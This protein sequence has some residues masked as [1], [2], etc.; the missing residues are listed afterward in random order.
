MLDVDKLDEL[1]HLELLASSD[2]KKLSEKL[3]RPNII[4]S[5]VSASS[6]S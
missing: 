4:I 3:D 6:E 2:L 1:D 5:L